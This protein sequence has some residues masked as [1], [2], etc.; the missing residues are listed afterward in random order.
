MLKFKRKW[1]LESL[2]HFF[3]TLWQHVS[4]VPSPASCLL[5]KAFV[6][7][8]HERAQRVITQANSCRLLA[9]GRIWNKCYLIL[10]IAWVVLKVNPGIM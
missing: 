6:R 9:F 1:Q 5:C 4:V 3:A 7:Y 2:R 8:L 10:K